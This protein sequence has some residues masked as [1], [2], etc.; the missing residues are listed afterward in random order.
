MA[1]KTGHYRVDY[2]YAKMREVVLGGTDV[3]LPHKGTIFDKYIEDL[4]PDAETRDF[5]RAVQ[6]APFSKAHP[7]DHQRMVDETNALA[8]IR[9][10]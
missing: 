9:S 10:K 2:E 1:S 7:K 8:A 4:F 6:E 5:L 3:M